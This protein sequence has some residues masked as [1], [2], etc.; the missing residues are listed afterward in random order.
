MSNLKNVQP[1]EDFNWEE[2]E[3]G[4]GNN[5]SKE[6]LVKAYDETLNKIAEHQ[7]VEG[8]VTHVDKKEVI[9]NIG[10]RV[11]VLFL[12]LNSDTTQT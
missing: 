7:V 12:H 8:T 1:L 3:N 4:S 9:V 6:A 10:T 11:M 2:F 5:A